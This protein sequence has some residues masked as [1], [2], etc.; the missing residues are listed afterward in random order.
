MSSEPFIA[1]D[2]VSFTPPSTLPLGFDV[3]LLVGA[4]VLLCVPCPT[5]ETPGVPPFDE[6][7]ACVPLDVVPPELVLLDVVPV[8]LVVLPPELVL[9]DV[10]PD[11]V[12]AFCPFSP[13]TVLGLV[14]D[15]V[16]LLGGGGTMQS[17]GIVPDGVVPDGVVPLGV[18]PDGVVLPPGVFESPGSFIGVSELNGGV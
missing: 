12:V 1:S 5:D 16:E 10:V 3:E 14:D 15:V 9:L 17:L 18:V 11:G 4:G 7:L 2:V 13:V 8:P 6:S